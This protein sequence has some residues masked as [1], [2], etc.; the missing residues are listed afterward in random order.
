M[1]VGYRNKA[2]VMIRW[3]W[4]YIGWRNGA[5]VLNTLYLKNDPLTEHA[6]VDKAVE[7]ELVGAGGR[8]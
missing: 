2:V 8:S 3:L 1:T 4:S 5:R 7:K 6:D